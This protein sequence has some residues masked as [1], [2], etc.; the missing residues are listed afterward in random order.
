MEPLA[1]AAAEVQ[2][3]LR[4][5]RY[6]RVRPAAMA[7]AQVLEP[8]ARLI[9]EVLL[10][11]RQAKLPSLSVVVAGQG[12]TEETTVAVV[13][14]AWLDARAG[15]EVVAL[16]RAVTAAVAMAP[17]EQ[18]T[19][20]VRAPVDRVA[21][22]HRLDLVEGRAVDMAAPVGNVSAI[23]P[24]T[25]TLSTADTAVVL[26]AATAMVTEPHGQAQA[27]AAEL[28]FLRTRL[29]SDPAHLAPCDGSECWIEIRLWPLDT[30]YC[31]R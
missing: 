14:P 4:V 24:M 2:A 29:R 31:P 21:S 18:V 10:S 8:Q 23:T 1:A 6:W 17:G 11:L 27:A 20:T 3:S 30:P 15:P 19:F 16:I 12:L 9:S 26:A 7:V 5:G 25:D 28:P 13:A 22:E